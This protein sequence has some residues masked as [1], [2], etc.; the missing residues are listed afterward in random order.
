MG[1]F[2]GFR[3]F[4]R[5]LGIFMVLRVFLGFFRVF[6]VFRVCRGFFMGFLGFFLGGGAWAGG[7]VPMGWFEHPAGGPVAHVSPV[8][9]VWGF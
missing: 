8:R 1:F 2:E 3:V 6:G 9:V 4:L 7:G 5:F